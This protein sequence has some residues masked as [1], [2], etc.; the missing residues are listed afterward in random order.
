MDRKDT[1]QNNTN[2][3]SSTLEDAKQQASSVLT[4]A[5]EAAS[6]AVSE[7]KQV[8][9]ETLEDTKQQARSTIDERKNQAADR[10]QG[11]ASA[12]RQTSQELGDQDEATFAHY[13]E[14]AAQQ[15]EKFSGYLKEKNLGELWGEVQGFARRQPDI[16]LVG[17]LAGGFLLGRFLKSSGSQSSA[18]SYGNYAQRQSYGGTSGFNY[19]PSNQG[20]SSPGRYSQS[21]YTSGQLGQ[22]GVSREFG[23]A[24]YGQGARGDSGQNRPGQGDF[25]Q[26][27]PG[28][29]YSSQA[30]YGQGQAGQGQYQPSQAGQSSSSA[31]QTAT[32]QNRADRYGTEQSSFTD[33]GVGQSPAEFVDTPTTVSS[34]YG[35]T[36]SSTA[37][38]DTDYQAKSQHGLGATESGDPKGWREDTHKTNDS[39]EWE[40][41]APKMPE[42]ELW[43]KEAREKDQRES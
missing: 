2:T 22:S 1:W 4:Q 9:V 14:G 40:A 37:Y 23:S 30:R 35:E 19:G 25:G 16:F 42:D 31:E 29:S 41:G 18:S 24:S 28:Q 26:D 5:K 13:A 43:S 27:Q 34:A 11:F 17:A 8:A 10:L 6:N 20:E 3:T 7:A 32:N 39:G 21:Q 12:L 33:Y 15:V 38:S 36:E